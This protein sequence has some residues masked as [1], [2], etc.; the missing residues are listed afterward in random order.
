VEGQ[1]VLDAAEQHVESTVDWLAWVETEV[2]SLGGRSIAGIR[3]A[4]PPRNLLGIL[5]KIARLRQSCANIARIRQ[6]D[7]R[8]GEVPTARA[9]WAATA[10]AQ[11]GEESLQSALLHDIFGNP[12]CQLPSAPGTIAPLAERVYA[13]EWE[14][15]P[16]LGEWLQEHGYWSEGEHCLDPNNNHVKGCWVVDWVTGRE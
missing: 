10:V 4:Y 5:T 1:L 11:V 12:F 7:A 16:I 15:M 3:L 9:A 2:R 13:G 14:F 6:A 8:S